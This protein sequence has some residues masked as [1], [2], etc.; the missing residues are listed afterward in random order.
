[1]LKEILAKLKDGKSN[2]VD[3]IPS[4]VLKYSGDYLQS[5]LLT[6]YNKILDE[7]L[8]PEKLNVIKCILLHKK[9]DSL[10][11]LNYRPIAV[12]S[13][14]LRPITMRLTEDMTQIVETSGTLGKISTHAIHFVLL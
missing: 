11:V 10:D 7:G 8:V 6:F 14:L 3:N 12:P 2:G 13:C 4:E 5:F 9:G 1:M